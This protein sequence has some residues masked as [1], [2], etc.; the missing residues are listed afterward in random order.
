MR[1][2]STQE[3]AI[4]AAQAMDDKLA[5]EIKVL[6]VSDVMVDADYFVI[7]SCQTMIQLNAIAHAV[8][9]KLKE[10]NVPLLRQEGRHDNQW[11]LLDYGSV[12]IHIF[13]AEER[14]Y[15][16]LEKLW[17]DAEVVPFE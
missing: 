2:L 16:S 10:L 1:N 9:D 7:G 6:K 8:L 5:E 11:V 3:I 14:E 17:A 13:T 15:Y 12:V 4:A